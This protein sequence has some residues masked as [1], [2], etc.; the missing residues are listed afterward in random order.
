MCLQCVWITCSLLRESGTTP[1][2]SDKV[3]AR[4]T[5][6]V[7]GGPTRWQ[8]PSLVN[9]AKHGRYQQF[10][11]VIMK[12]AR[13]NGGVDW[14]REPKAKTAQESHEQAT[15]KQGLAQAAQRILVVAHLSSVGGQGV[16]QRSEAMGSLSDQRELEVAQE[17]MPQELYIT[18]MAA[19]PSSKGGQEISQCP[20]G[21]MHRLQEEPDLLCCRQQKGCI[22]TVSSSLPVVYPKALFCTILHYRLY[23][24]QSEV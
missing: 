1:T 12:R 17:L 24:S 23:C 13:S 7:T 2:R 8:A 10:V 16:A 22:K 11:G 18:F 6:V 4:N 19:L 15:Q 20:L 3:G 14:Y 9:R 21:S 5:R